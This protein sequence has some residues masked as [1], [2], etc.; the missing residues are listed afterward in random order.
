[1]EGYRDMVRQLPADAPALATAPFMNDE[2]RYV[3]RHF[4]GALML[5]RYRQILGDDKFFGAC[6]EFF[7]ASA[8]RAIGTSDFRGFWTEKPSDRKSLVGLWLDSR[9]GLP[10][11]EPITK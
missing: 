6:R 11:A 3:A 8:G 5:D 4:K 1:M 9:G 10:E 2:V 7:R